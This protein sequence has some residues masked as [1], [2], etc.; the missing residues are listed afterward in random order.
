MEQVAQS[1]GSPIPGN[2]PGQVGWGSEQPDL[3]KEVPDHG[4]GVAQMILPTETIL[5]FYDSL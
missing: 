1:S 5:W 4:R 2:I 3:V